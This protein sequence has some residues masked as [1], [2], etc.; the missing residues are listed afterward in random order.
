MYADTHAPTRGHHP[1]GAQ[2]APRRCAAAL[3]V[4]VHRCGLQRRRP[5]RTSVSVTWRQVLMEKHERGIARLC[6]GG[7]RWI[8]RICIGMGRRIARACVLPQGHGPMAPWTRSMKSCR[9]SESER[10]VYAGAPKAADRWLCGQTL[11]GRWIDLPSQQPRISNYIY[12]E[13]ERERERELHLLQLRKGR[14]VGPLSNERD[15][16]GRAARHGTYLLHT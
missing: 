7:G 15:P 3:S 5:C 8:A 13:R 10:C 1:E 9:A 4:H 14:Q 6:I 12:R 16:A 2:R 11:F